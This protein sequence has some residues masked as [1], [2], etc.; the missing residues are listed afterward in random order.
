MNEKEETIRKRALE[1]AA[2]IAEKFARANLSFG[3]NDGEALISSS[4]AQAIANT[5]RELA[6]GLPR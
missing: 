3:K 4:I 6:A 2:I 5:I 1:D